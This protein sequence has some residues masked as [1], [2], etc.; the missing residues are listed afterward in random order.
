MPQEIRHLLESGG[1]FDELP[2]AYGEFGRTIT[3]PIPV[4][5]PIGEIMY[6]SSLAT[7]DGRFLLGHRVGSKGKV[8]I[9][10]TVTSDGVSWDIL[11][12]SLY[13]PK[14]SKLTPAGLTFSNSTHP[15][16]HATNVYE[17]EFPVSIAN[18][19]SAWTKGFLGFSLV[20][21]EVRRAVM[22]VH[23]TRPAAH[24]ARLS[25]LRIDGQSS[26]LDPRIAMLKQLVERFTATLQAVW[27]KAFG[28]TVFDL[29]ELIFFSASI[30]IYAYL[31]F[32][33]GNRDTNMVDEFSVSLLSD[34][35]K[36]S[37]SF[38]DGRERYQIRY[39][40]YSALFDSMFGNGDFQGRELITI[41]MHAVERATHES[42]RGKM[43]AI[44]SIST[45]IAAL[46][47]EAITL[48]RVEL[49]DQFDS[50][51]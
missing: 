9:F 38:N 11:Y 51:Q 41:M 27:K 43:I 22:T 31:R 1:S 47:D 32:G 15:R 12:L 50:T 18:A 14:K 44:A 26:R 34:A 7:T 45:V 6:L 4:N 10:E 20:P 19:V 39:Q 35:V 37:L 3:N 36:R 33:Q 2:Q 48:A 30:A 24:A 42:A 29:N 23:F 25:V 5:G 28:P 49:S 17:Q 13:H 40:E 21:A 16:I 8:D 46:F